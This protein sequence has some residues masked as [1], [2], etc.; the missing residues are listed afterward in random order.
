MNG[1]NNN[2]RWLNDNNNNLGDL[3]DNYL[4]DSI[5]TTEIILGDFYLTGSTFP[6]TEGKCSPISC[7]I[8]DMRV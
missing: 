8:F 4:G 5:I 2:F 7:N 1:N 3:N 6:A